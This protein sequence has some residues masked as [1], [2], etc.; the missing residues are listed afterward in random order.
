MSSNINPNNINGNFPVAG[1]DNDSQGF[2]DNFTNILNNFSFAATEI[3]ALQSATTSVQT[4]VQSNGN[5]EAYYGNI[6]Q[7][8]TVNKT[9]HLIGAA[10]LDSNLYVT[11]STNLAG[12]LNVTTANITVASMGNVTI[13]NLIQA[14]SHSSSAYQYFA[15]TG[16]VTYSM[17]SNI[18]RFIL[19]PSGTITNMAVTLPTA[20]IDGMTVTLSSTAQITNLQVNPNSGC[21][22]TPGANIL[23]AGGTGVTYFFLK[24]AGKWLKVV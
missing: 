3:N 21:T 1:Q 5:I 24:S 20:N 13:S 18:T 22:L 23:L 10:T 19:N 11:G 12:N 6:A 17:Y 8:L 15:P 9:T 2:R 4:V 16:N 7:G 14:G